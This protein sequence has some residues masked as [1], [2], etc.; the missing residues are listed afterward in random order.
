MAQKEGV[1][2]PQGSP[3]GTLRDPRYGGEAATDGSEVDLRWDR[4]WR[5]GKLMQ[6]P[7]G[8]LNPLW[9]SANS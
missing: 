8:P 2:S 3:W 9:V 6:W 7:I 4:G 5:Y 1:A